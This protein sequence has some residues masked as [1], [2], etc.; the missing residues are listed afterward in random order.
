[1][2][3]A[4]KKN[5]KIISIAVLSV[6]GLLFLVAGY[7]YAK[8]VLAPTYD[9]ETMPLNYEVIGSGKKNILLIHG[10]AGSKNYWKMG[11]KEVKATHRLLLVDLLG[12]GDSPKPQSDYSLKTQLEALEQVIIK[13]GMD[14]GS[15]IVV[16]H[17]MGATISLALFAEHPNWFDGATVIGLPIFKS[18]DQFVSNMSKASVFDRIAIGSSGKVFCLLHPIYLSKWFKPKNLTDDVF[19]DSRKHTWQSYHHSLNEIILGNNLYS[20]TKNI[21]AKEILFIHGAEDRA[22]PLSNVKE[23]AKTFTNSKLKTM[24]EGDHHLF[25]KMPKK[26]WKIT[27]AFFDNDTKI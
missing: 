22:A 18:R 7:E 20:T 19:S 15:T 13:E 9:P 5:I 24:E 10:L 16:G 1:M 3:R 21:R 12:F 14:N 23:F 4:I 8:V 25:L 11:L 17:S 2:K 27:M 26:V 6:L